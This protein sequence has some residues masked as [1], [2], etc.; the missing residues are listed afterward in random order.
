[1]EMK[2]INNT[3]K[4]RNQLC[5]RLYAASRNMT[6]L[7]K[8]L[9]EKYNLT[10][11]QYIILLVLFEEVSIDFKELSDVVDL[12]T[13]TL[14]PIV[15]KLVELGY[16]NKVKNPSDGRKLNVVITKKGKILETKIDDVPKCLLKAL[17][18]SEDEYTNLIN[19]IDDLLDKLKKAQIKKGDLK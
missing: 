14:T 6:R 8:P 13:A 19:Q 9:L 16:A 12:K 1:M 10:Y 11:P 7:Y 15:N 17:D 5:F 3:L 4:I 18:I 2:T